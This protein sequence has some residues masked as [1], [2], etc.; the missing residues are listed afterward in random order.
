MDIEVLFEYLDY[1]GFLGLTFNDQ[2]KSG[3][4]VDVEAVGNKFKV[5]TYVIAHLHFWHGL[6][7]CPGHFVG[8]REF[9]AIEVLV[10]LP[11][12]QSSGP[13]G[14]RLQRGSL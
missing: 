3:L 11:R 7:D 10:K 14:F 8:V 2:R 6:D 4:W 5:A 9:L 13:Q 12:H 1:G